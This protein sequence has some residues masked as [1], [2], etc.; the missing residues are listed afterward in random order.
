MIWRTLIRLRFTIILTIVACACAEGSRRLPILLW[1]RVTEADVQRP[2][3][4]A[5]ERTTVPLSGP[6]IYELLLQFPE[7]WPESGAVGARWSVTGD[8]PSLDPSE[9]KPIRRS[10]SSDGLSSAYLDSVHIRG[11]GNQAFSIELDLVPVIEA[12]GEFRLIVRDLD[13]VMAARQGSYTAYFL[14]Q[15][16]WFFLVGA[17]LAFVTEALLCWRAFRAEPGPG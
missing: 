12:A 14:R 10:L 1:R 17:A 13:L 4:A 11:P 5:H 2:I 3:R 7:L 8:E 9:W 15:A 6:G 16:S